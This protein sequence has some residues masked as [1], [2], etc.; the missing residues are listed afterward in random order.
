MAPK[1]SYASLNP[2]IALQSRDKSCRITG[3]RKKTQ[4]VHICPQ[5][6]AKWWYGNGTS[7]CNTLLESSIYIF[8]SDSSFVI[9]K[10]FGSNRP[11]SHSEHESGR[12]FY[13]FVTLN[14]KQ[15]VGK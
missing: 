11:P 10:T 2:P 7:L 14:S 5:K 8:D 3:C 6:D 9:L 12:K 4:V 1:R 13:L 15:H